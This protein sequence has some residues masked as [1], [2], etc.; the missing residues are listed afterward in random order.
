MEK[1]MEEKR[2][3]SDSLLDTVLDPIIEIELAE[4]QTPEKQSQIIF[5][6][7]SSPP[8]ISSN[9]S[10]NGSYDTKNSYRVGNRLFDLSKISYEDIITEDDEPVDNF[11][12]EKQQRLL[13]NSLYSSNHLE[14]PFV[15][16]ANVGVHY[17]PG[18][19]AIV[20][21]VFLSLNA[22][23]VD[24]DDIMDK[25]NRTY[26]V[27]KM[28]KP[29]EVVMEIVSNRK[30]NETDHKFEKYATV[31]A[32]YYVILDHLRQAQDEL[33]TVYELVDGHYE[34]RDDYLLPEVNLSLTILDD[35]FEDMRW[36]WVRWCDLEGT[37][38]PMADELAAQEQ[39][40]ADQ[41]QERADQEQERADQEKERA[42]QAEAAAAQA[43][44]E[45]DRRVE[46][47]LAELRA[48]GIEIDI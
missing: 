42:D 15:A 29:P 22:K 9:G 3:L 23:T 14:R 5:T 32:K 16:A 24:G 19:P 44:A 35:T 1:Q 37:M 8:N 20:P 38:I 7:G 4:V 10:Q 36:S 17:Q 12:S 11:P 46:R 28:K 25:E 21:D 33:L 26:Y 41:E 31:G 40:R 13:V 2:P 30:G 6:N 43:K 39:E 34:L 45:A 47:A 27:W 18:V 48:A